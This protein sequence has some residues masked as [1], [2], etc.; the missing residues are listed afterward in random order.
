MKHQ[1]L[2]RNINIA[3]LIY[4]CI[5]FESFFVFSSISMQMKSI[6]LPD[7]AEFARQIKRLHLVDYCIIDSIYIHFLLVYSL[8]L[9]GKFYPV[10]T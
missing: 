9:A 3:P 8:T 7:H 5:P 10:M 1:R 4:I 6:F 2:N